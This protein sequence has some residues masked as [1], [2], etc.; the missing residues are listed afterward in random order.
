MF[1]LWRNPTW[2]VLPP[3]KVNLTECLLSGIAENAV[4][5]SYDQASASTLGC[6][7]IYLN[8]KSWLPELIILSSAVFATS[9]FLACNPLQAARV[10]DCLD[11]GGSYD[12]ESETCDLEQ[13]H[14]VP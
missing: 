13:S 11:R 4:C 1:Q 5:S 8:L 9:P 10:D 3:F 6:F 12:Y 14:P 7:Q 2:A